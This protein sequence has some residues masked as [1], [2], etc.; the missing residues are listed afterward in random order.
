MFEIVGLEAQHSIHIFMIRYNPEQFRGLSR[1]KLHEALNA[2]GIP[3]FSGYTHAIYNNP[4]FLEKKFYGKNCP[5]SCSH[6]GTELDYAAYAERCPVSE[7]AC[8]GEAIWP[9]HRLFLGQHKDMD[10]IAD[11]FA[12]VKENAAELL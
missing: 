7:R 8:A 4:M 12:K 11:A 6:Y 2:E 9:E 1:S 3:A 10:D 5:I